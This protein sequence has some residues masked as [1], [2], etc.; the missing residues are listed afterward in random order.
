MRFVDLRDIY[1][2]LLF[3]FCRTCRRR[4]TRCFFCGPPNCNSTA[5]K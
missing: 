4:F 3:K 2:L 5:I 1:Y